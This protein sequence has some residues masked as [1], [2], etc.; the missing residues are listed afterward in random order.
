MN[1]AVGFQCPNCGHQE[2]DLLEIEMDQNASP[3]AYRLHCTRCEKV[4]TE[5]RLATDAQTRRPEPAP[6]RLG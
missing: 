1:L 3:I 2:A 5:L 4:Y 6:R